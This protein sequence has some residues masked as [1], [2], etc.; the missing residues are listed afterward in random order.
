MPKNT[1]MQRSAEIFAVP[2]RPVTQGL[3]LGSSVSRAFAYRAHGTVF[4]TRSGGQKYLEGKHCLNRSPLPRKQQGPIF[5]SA[6]KN[7]Q[8]GKNI[9]SPILQRRSYI[10]GWCVKLN[11]NIRK[12]RK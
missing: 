12:E 7:S 11:W 3:G 8:V 10:H 4:D 9:I 1:E 5:W 2:A 6:F